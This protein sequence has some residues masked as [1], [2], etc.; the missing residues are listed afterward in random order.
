MFTQVC[1]NAAICPQCRA[2]ASAL[3]QVATG[4]RYE[5][6]DTTLS[7]VDTQDGALAEPNHPDACHKCHKFGFL[8]ECDGC[9]QN[10][11]FR[12]SGLDWPPEESDPFSCEMCAEARAATTRPPDASAT[13]SDAGGV[14]MAGG[15]GIGAA[16]AAPL[17][18]AQQRAQEASA[19]AARFQ[20][21]QRQ[22]VRAPDI[23]SSG[24]EP[25]PGKQV[26]Y[27]PLE[28]SKVRHHQ[29]LTLRTPTPSLAGSTMLV[30]YHT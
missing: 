29:P 3:V 9:K 27:A 30:L 8:I 15:G 12:C 14:A 23:A 21:Q 19:R 16:Q 20:Q 17:E 28:T 25:L 26:E 4:R 1:G 2:P 6:T 24:P 10:R 18:Q 13:Q 11:C 5:V 7:L 22:R